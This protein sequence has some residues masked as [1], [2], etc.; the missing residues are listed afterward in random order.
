MIHSDVAYLLGA[1]R[2][3]TIDIRR[4]KNYEIK[5]IQKNYEWLRYI[6]SIIYRQFGV[7]AAIHGYELRLTN[8]LTVLNLQKLSE[9]KR[10]Q[11]FWGTPQVIKSSK[12]LFVIRSY[13]Q[14]FWDAEGGLPIDLK[15]TKGRYISFDQKNRESISFIR[16]QL[17]H[18]GMHPTKFYFTGNVWQF[19]LHRKQDI[20]SCKIVIGSKHPEKNK[21]LHELASSLFP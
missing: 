17:R 9:M 5:I 1:L 6:Q 12:D 15:K 13:I 8:K 18:L 2:D 3:G 20:F 10:P 4:G 7:Y 19:R 11:H 16:N 21:R 14:G